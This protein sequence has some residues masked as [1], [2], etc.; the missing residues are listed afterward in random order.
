[1]RFEEFLQRAREKFG[2]RFLYDPWSWETST[3]IG[4]GRLR[5]RCPEH[6]WQEMNPINHLNSPLGCPRCGN[7]LAGDKRR[8]TTEELI[9][10][11]EVVHDGK[12]GYERTT[13][14]S[15][16]DKVVITCPDHG[17][18]S[19]AAANHMAGH[20]CP[21]CAPGGFD[22]D[23]PTIVYYIR[24]ERPDGTCYKIGI[25]NLSVSERYPCSSDQARITILREW[26]YEVGADAAA[27]EKQVL[28]EHRRHRYSGPP[29]LTGVGVTGVFT[30][31][32]LGLDGGKRPHPAQISLFD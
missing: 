12:Y 30:C 10:R 24:I 28:Q 19:Q 22:P 32:V 1:M 23:L 2:Y 14:T 9:A 26:R 18:F 13:Y 4:L 16:A 21:A 15:A 25:S 20:G 27:H 8:L 17:D 29:V 3:N 11:S 6:G 31:D 5:V 7:F